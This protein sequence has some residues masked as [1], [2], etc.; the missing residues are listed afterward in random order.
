M[1]WNLSKHQDRMT[2]MAIIFPD[3]KTY[4]QMAL[5]PVHAMSQQDSVISNG[6]CVYIDLPPEKVQQLRQARSEIVL[7]QNC[8]PCFLA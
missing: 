8:L 2:T 5:V 6:D 4:R 1:D 7:V 3:A